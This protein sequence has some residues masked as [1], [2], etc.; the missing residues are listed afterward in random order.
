MTNQYYDPEA[1]TE[2]VM[3]EV[4]ASVVDEIE[5]AVYDEG[6]P[7]FDGRVAD[8]L[9]AAQPVLANYSKTV[10]DW[11]NNGACTKLRVDRTTGR[12]VK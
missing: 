12:S 7:D 8:K 1:A 2:L 6:L 11:L 10:L 4:T 5:Q 9:A 3:K